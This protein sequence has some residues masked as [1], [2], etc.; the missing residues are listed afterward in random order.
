MARV[1]VVCGTGNVFSELVCVSG[2]SGRRE[3]KVLT[4]AHYCEGVKYVQLRE[5]HTLIDICI[6]TGIKRFA[7]NE[8]VSRSHAGS[9]SRFDDKI[10]IYE[11]QKE[12]NRD[13]KFTGMFDIEN[14][15]S[16]MPENGHYRLAMT[17]IQDLAK[18]LDEALAHGGSG[19]IEIAES[20]QGRLF[21]AITIPQ[22][23]LEAGKLGVAW[24]AKLEQPPHFKPDEDWDSVKEFLVEVWDGQP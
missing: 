17:K 16:L 15:R 3:T 10:E 21:E 6:E 18:I 12:V 23:T 2:Q 7:P 8:W 5:V 14:R 11:Y 4:R 9:F 24:D 20:V 19:I 22:S 1:A 13:N